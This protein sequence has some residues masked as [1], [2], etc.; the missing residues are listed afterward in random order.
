MRVPCSGGHPGRPRPEVIGVARG[1]DAPAQQGCSWNPALGSVPGDTRPRW[2]VRSHT[3]CSRGF[4][5]AS[6]ALR[7][8]ALEIREDG[9][10][11][12]PGWRTRRPWRLAGE[13]RPPGSVAQK[14]RVWDRRRPHGCC[15]HVGAGGPVHS[16]TSQRLED[17]HTAEAGGLN[18]RKFTNGYPSSCCMS[19]PCD[20]LPGCPCWDPLAPQDP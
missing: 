19:R 9:E 17:V 8:A 20:P 2:Q 6:P 3:A 1:A 4:R 16:W 7:T 14:R 13:A 5:D 10:D 11:P 18:A 15:G 12:G